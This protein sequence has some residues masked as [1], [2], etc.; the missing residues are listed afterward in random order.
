MKDNYP[1]ILIVVYPSTCFISL[2]VKCISLPGVNMKSF[3]FDDYFFLAE[4]FM[5]DKDSAK[6]FFDYLRLS[7][8]NKVI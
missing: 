2:L 6:F 8:R 5:K 4:M 7:S 3:S 1:R